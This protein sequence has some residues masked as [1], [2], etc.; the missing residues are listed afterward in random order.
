MLKRISYS[1]YSF[2]YLEGEE[3]VAYLHPL[4][5]LAHEY[6]GPYNRREASETMRC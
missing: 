4:R 1:D 3:P 6:G 2:T 5:S